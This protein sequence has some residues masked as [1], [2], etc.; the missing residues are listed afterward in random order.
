MVELGLRVAIRERKALGQDLVA[1]HVVPGLDVV[2]VARELCRL[3][4]GIVALVERVGGRLRRDRGPDRLLH[5]RGQTVEHDAGVAALDALPAAEGDGPVAGR[6]ALDDAVVIEG[7]RD[8]RVRVGEDIRR[9]CA[10]IEL[11]DRRNIRADLR[12]RR[13]GIGDRAGRNDAVVLRPAPDVDIPRAGFAG[14]AGSIH[15]R[16]R[17]DELDRLGVADRILGQESPVAVAV[18]HAL[19]GHRGDLIVIVAVGRDVREA[20]RGVRPGEGDEP[21][22]QGK[23][24]QQAK[25]CAGFFYRFFLEQ[26]RT[27]HFPHR[28]MQRLFFSLCHPRRERKRQN[29]SFLSVRPSPYTPRVP[30]ALRFRRGSSGRCCPCRARA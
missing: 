14:V 26:V 22:R 23:Q 15:A 30:G 9:C 1:E 10:R 18:D 25:D 28:A 27:P 7:V 24:E 17:D 3:R 11:V 20:A 5:L 21:R 16:H 4:H 2:A 6:D 19:R 12:A 29:S 13:V 8:L